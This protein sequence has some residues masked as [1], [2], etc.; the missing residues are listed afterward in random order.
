MPTILQDAFT[1][2]AAYICRTPAVKETILQ[3]AEERSSA[4]A[5]QGA[6]SADGAQG[7]LCHLAHVQALLV[8]EFIR[9]F[10]GSVRLRA[11]AEQQLPTLRRWVTRMWEAVKRYRGEDDFPKERPLHWNAND[12]DREYDTTLK[13]WKLWILT[14]SVRRTQTIIDTIANTYQTMTK[15][16]AECSGAVMITARRGLWEAESAAKWY[17]LSCTKA[18]LLV[19]SLQPGPLISQHAAEDIDDFV[20]TLWTFLI[21]TDK[22]QYWTDKSIRMSWT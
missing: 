9:L 6:P 14:E 13:L 1:T 19:P 11:S 10:Y 12:L 3:I 7:I 15:G 16:W 22:I 20:K 21:G 2:L 18:P 5:R 4:L 8:Y 17:E